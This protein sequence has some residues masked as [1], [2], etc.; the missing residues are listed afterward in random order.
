MEIDIFM[1][2]LTAVKMFKPELEKGEKNPYTKGNEIGNP[3]MRDIKLDI[4]EEH[5]KDV[6]NLLQSKGYDVSKFTM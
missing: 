6:L 5:I 4:E 3:Y 1:F 2:Q